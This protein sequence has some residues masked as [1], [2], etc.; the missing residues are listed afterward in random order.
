L[1]RQ[2]WQRLASD[3]RPKSLGRIAQIIPFNELPQV[4]P[5]MMQG[6][7]RGR[8]VIEINQQG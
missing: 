2:I 6:K 4:F 1:R 8:R 5:L 3:L 7:L